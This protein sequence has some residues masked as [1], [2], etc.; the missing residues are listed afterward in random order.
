MSQHGLADKKPEEVDFESVLKGGFVLGRF[1]AFEV[2]FP[3]AGL[4]KHAADFRDCGLALL[5]AQEKLF[6]WNKPAG[7][8]QKALRADFKAV[9]DWIKAW[10]VPA[11]AKARDSAGKDVTAVLAASESVTAAS[12]RL[13]GSLGKG[14][15]LGLARE[16]PLR[17]R[18]VLLPTRKEFVELAC[19]IGMTSPDEKA[20]YWVD[21]VADWATCWV[22]DTQVIALEY[23]APNHQPEDYVSGEN[24]NERDPT[25]MQQQVVQFSIQRLFEQ[26]FSEQVPANFVGGLSMTLVVDQFGEISTRVDGDLR[27]KTTQGR[28]VFV[29]GVRGDGMLGK[30]SA[31]SRWREDRG[32]DRFVRI[33]HQ[34]QK[35][36]DGLDK[37]FKNRVA[38]FGVR[39]DAGGELAPVHAPF[40]NPDP[41]DPKTPA[42]V[43]QGD[44]AELQRAYK[45]SFISWLQ[46]KAG[47]GEKVSREKFAQLLEKIGDPKQPFA[48]AFPATYE[49]SPLTDAEAGKDSL[50]GKF[51]L[52]LSKQK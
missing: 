4:E 31:E 44:Y 17:I 15:E 7:H 38:V 46:S 36:G 40:L 12:E 18:M 25:V 13:V 14:E 1:G 39:S 33:L 43:F 3:V 52:W 48:A 41:A 2:Y 21:G 9:T 8:D 16:T 23:A 51:L 37:T 6:D 42:K 5:G 50:E 30:N 47:A 27:G 26:V 45:C 22:Q 35:E 19:F 24:M 11:L 28:S 20:T 49:T 29:P 34:S 10:R 32:R